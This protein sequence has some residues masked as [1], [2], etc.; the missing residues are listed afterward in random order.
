MIL[1]MSNLHAAKYSHILY[2]LVKISKIVSFW[3]CEY[4]LGRFSQNYFYDMLHTYID[5]HAVGRN[6]IVIGRLTCGDLGLVLDH[7]R[8]RIKLVELSIP[9]EDTNLPK[10][11]LI[12]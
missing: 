10:S 9:I 1:T 5:E 12:I 3:K 4:D 7:K 11:S 6:N 8:K 2:I